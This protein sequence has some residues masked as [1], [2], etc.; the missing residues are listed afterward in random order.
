MSVHIPGRCSQGSY[1]C[2]QQPRNENE[3]ILPG[4]DEVECRQHKD[5]VD[6]QPTDDGDCVHAQLASHG[7]DVLHLHD[8]TSNQ[9]QDTNRG[10]PEG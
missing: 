4:D 5:G 3:G 8:F 2:L 1:E 7:G 10:V 9:E 6:E